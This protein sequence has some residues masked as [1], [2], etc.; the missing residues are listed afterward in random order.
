MFG[1]I[2][3]FMLVSLLG[4]DGLGNKF[5]KESNVR[6]CFKI[7]LLYVVFKSAFENDWFYSKIILIL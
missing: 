3:D 4:E 6:L 7:K 5:E 1:S 2:L